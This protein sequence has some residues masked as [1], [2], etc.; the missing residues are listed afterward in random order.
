MTG[1]RPGACCALAALL[2]IALV[3]SAARAATFIVNAPNDGWLGDD[4]AIPSHI[5][6]TNRPFTRPVLPP[7]WKLVGTNPTQPM[8]S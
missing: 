4:D 3:P 2:L 1:L 6:R 8:M 5:T 7:A